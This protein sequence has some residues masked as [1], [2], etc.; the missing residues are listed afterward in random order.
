MH[1]VIPERRKHM[2]G[3]ARAPGVSFQTAVQ[4]GKP[5]D[6]VVILIELTK[7]GKGTKAWRATKGDGSVLED[8]GA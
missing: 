3:P 2:T 7:L 5:K 4:R 1:E 8:E 6:A